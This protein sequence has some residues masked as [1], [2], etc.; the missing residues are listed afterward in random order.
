MMLIE[1][2]PNDFQEVQTE[3]RPLIFCEFMFEK[4]TFDCFNFEFEREKL[5]LIEEC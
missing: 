5:C 3:T 2:F 1:T 4:F